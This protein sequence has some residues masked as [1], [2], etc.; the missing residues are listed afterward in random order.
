[1]GGLL[2]SSL[3]FAAIGLLAQTHALGQTPVSRETELLLRSPE[4]KLDV[5]IAALTL[6]KEVYPDLHIPYYSKKIDLLAS[7]AQ[8]VIA[9]QGRNDPDSV[10][11]ALNTFF[12]KIHGM[13]YDP[14]VEA[15]EKRENYFLVKLLDTKEGTCANMP[16][17]YMAVAQRLGYP[18]Y[19][20]AIPEHQ[21]LRYVSPTLKEA[22]IEATGGGGF[23][24]DAR[25]IR[26]SRVGEIGLKESDY[27]KTLSNR[28]WLAHLVESTA[29]TISKQ[30]KLDKAIYL[31]EKSVAI[32]PKCAGCYH[33]LGASYLAKAKKQTTQEAG[34][35]Y[36]NK[37][38]GAFKR[39][40]ELGYVMPF[41]KRA[42]KRI[43]ES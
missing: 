5:G 25:Y 36:W 34:M 43:R 30:G 38:D 1:V 42:D 23:I 41:T 9:R 37:A 18:V 3:C 39:S 16:V 10:I 8:Q 32:N 40:K 2:R 13:Y 6:A 28:E 4:S 17:L 31:L 19:S 7:Q 14:S 22:N 24:P 11:R 26:E 35:K 21:F 29:V 15:W 12:Y 20:V 33:N 27:L